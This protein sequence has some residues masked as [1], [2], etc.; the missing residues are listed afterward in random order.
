MAERVFERDGVGRVDLQ[1]RVGDA[2]NG[3]HGRPQDLWLVQPGHAGVDVENRRAGL[4]LRN[5]LAEN[6]TGVAGLVGLAELFLAGWVDA[7]ADDD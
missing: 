7:L 2:L 4:D 5:R 3:L 6:V 1:R